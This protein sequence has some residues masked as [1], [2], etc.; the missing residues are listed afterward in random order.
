[1]KNLADPVSVRQCSQGEHSTSSAPS[2][3]HQNIALSAPDSHDHR[4]QVCHTINVP[5]EERNV[6]CFCKRGLAGAKYA[7]DSQAEAEKACEG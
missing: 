7:H 5:Q 1:M 2:K 4:K 3:P 6:V